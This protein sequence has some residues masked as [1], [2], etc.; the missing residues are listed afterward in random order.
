MVTG[1]AVMTYVKFGTPLAW[2]WYSVVGSGTTFL[3]GWMASLA[4]PDELATAGDANAIATS[5]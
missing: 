4:L 3:T 2:P 5:E 1:L